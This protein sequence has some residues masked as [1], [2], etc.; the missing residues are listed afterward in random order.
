[1]VITWHWTGFHL[2][3]TW[4]SRHRTGRPPVSADVWT[5]IRTMWH[6]TPRWGAPRIHGERLNLGLDSS[7]ATVTK[8]MVR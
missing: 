5:L 4:K 2:W 7:E 8:Y 6:A 3:W 1:M